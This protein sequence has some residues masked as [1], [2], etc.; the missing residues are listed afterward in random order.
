MIE[1]MKEVLGLERVSDFNGEHVMR[2]GV[3]YN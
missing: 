1:G 2:E 3:G